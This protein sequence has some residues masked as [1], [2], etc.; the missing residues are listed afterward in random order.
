MMTP[1]GY[2]S[3][4]YFFS[5]YHIF[6]IILGYGLLFARAWFF[7]KKG[8]RYAAVNGKIPKLSDIKYIF[9]AIGLVVPIVVG[10]IPLLKVIGLI[11]SLVAF[12]KLLPEILSL[13]HS[14]SITPEKMAFVGLGLGLAGTLG[15]IFGVYRG[16]SDVNS[17]SNIDADSKIGADID[18]SADSDANSLKPSK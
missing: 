4:F 10:F 6:I 14:K 1:W 8:V 18:G 17:I 13:N 5:A 3:F 7:Y 9:F 15:F 2:F 11:V 12:L 16:L